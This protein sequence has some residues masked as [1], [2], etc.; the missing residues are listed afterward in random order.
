LRIVY[1]KTELC[2]HFEEIEHPAVRETLRFLGMEQG[3]EIHYDGDLP[4]RSGMGSSSSFTV[5]LLHALYTLKGIMPSKK[6]LA[7]ESIHIEQNMI[8]ETVGSQDQVCA[9]FGGLNQIIFST[10]GEI[11]VRS[12][13]L[14][15]ARKKELD[16]HLMLFY[17]GIKRTA[18]E[19]ANGYVEDIFSKNKV[20]KKI[21]EMV[22]KGLDVLKSGS[23]I[24][25]F[26]ELLHEGWMLKR[27]LSPQVTNGMVDILYER[28][29]RAGAIG[30]KITGA[31]GGGFLLLF[32]P[33][34]AQKK[35][36][37]AL[38]KYI[39]VPFHFESS[40]SQIIFYEPEQQD[41]SKLEKDRAR[42]IISSFKELDSIRKFDKVAAGAAPREY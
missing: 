32:V 42:R 34:A 2:S 36:R 7:L 37:E 21:G 12:V 26:G 22:D 24:S 40:G 18:S 8:K 9:S 1:S 13:T 27:S 23:C 14:P 39:H 15:M 11:D 29:R 35:V 19:V 5:G 25:Q 10:D 30:G 38:G 16:S 31:G 17:T 41:Y 3:L 28:A 4:A 6:Q 20:L 33:P